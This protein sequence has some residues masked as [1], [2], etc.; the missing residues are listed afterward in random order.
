MNGTLIEVLDR[1]DEVEDSD[2]YLPKI[3][4]EN[5]L[6]T[7]CRSLLFAVLPLF[8]LT[9]SGCDDTTSAPTTPSVRPYADVAD[10]ESRG[11]PTDHFAMTGYAVQRDGRIRLT[12][13]ADGSAETE[14]LIHA[15]IE[16][17]RQLTTTLRQSHPIELVF[18]DMT[19]D[20][21]STGTNEVLRT[22]QLDQDT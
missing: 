7:S 14:D 20:D 13:Y 3:I 12:Y 2:R 15:A 17:A 16:D 5:H 6:M 18:I 10:L 22:V 1:L 9:M 11:V 8:G 21:P 4:P 19:V